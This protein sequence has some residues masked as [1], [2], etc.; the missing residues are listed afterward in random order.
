MTMAGQTFPRGADGLVLD[1]ETMAVSDA[2]HY[3]DTAVLEAIEPPKNY[4]KDEA[5]AEYIVR[6]TERIKLE[7]I[8]KAALDPDLCRIAVL[9]WFD[10][11]ACEPVLMQ[12]RDEV[13]EAIALEAFWS[14]LNMG[15]QVLGFNILTF[16]LPVICRRSLYLGVPTPYLQR[17]R[18]R[19]PRVL[20]LLDILCE[21]GRL[22]MRSV[23]FYCKRFGIQNDDVV[24]GK[25]VPSLL[26]DG[27]WDE[28]ISHCRHDLF[29]ERA[30]AQRLGLVKPLPV[31]LA[32]VS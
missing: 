30:I 8:D 23:G 16:D 7:H 13:E 21:Q 17:E 2:I 22:K 9:G 32:E 25:D 3:L 6:E 4:T 1:I 27:R 29:A 19:H 20:D 18:Y 24:K 31:Q 28:V 11:A 10:V 5:K 14:A 26:A 15:G 12:C